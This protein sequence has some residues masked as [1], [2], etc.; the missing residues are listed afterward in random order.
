LCPTCLNAKA[1]FFFTNDTRLTSISNIKFLTLDKLK[2]NGV[3]LTM[4]TQLRLYTINK[5]KLDEFAKV[6][7][8]N[9]YPLRLKFGFKIQGAWTIPER[10]EF[11]WMLSYDGPD[12]WETQ[13]KAY[14]AS[15]ERA[16]LNPDPAQYIAK[17]EHWFVNSIS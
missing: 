3:I 17:I 4:A 15:P 9:V 13:D 6:W 10:N 11:I 1:L 2:K 16:A 7:R 8:E 14:Y 5:G 12:G